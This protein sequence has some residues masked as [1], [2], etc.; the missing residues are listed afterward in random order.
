ME[1]ALTYVFWGALLQGLFL[2]FIY[3]FLDKQKNLSN[4]LL[5][6]FLIAIV[7]EAFTTILPFNYL[8]SYYVA[9]YFSLPEVKLFI[10]LLFLHFVMQ[11]LGLASKYRTFLKI[12]YFLATAIASLFILNL[13]YYIN[14]SSSIVENFGITLTDRVHYALQCYAFVVS[15]L[16]FFVLLKEVANYRALVKSEF[17]DYAMLQIKWLWQIIFAMLPV[18]LLWGLELLRI[19][20]RP[21]VESYFVSPIWIFITIFIYFISYRAYKNP[22]LFKEF[23]NNRFLG[24]KSQTYE[25]NSQIRM[26]INTLMAENEFY[27]NHDLTIHQFAKEVD[28]P[29]RLISACI[30]TAYQQNFNEWV[31]GFRVKKACELIKNDS[32]HNLSLEGIGLESGFK[33]RSVFYSA[34]KNIMGQTPGQFR[35]NQI[36]RT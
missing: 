11:K 27:L 35:P 10:P 30:N 26:Q 16:V 20:I 23:P 21:E 19:L 3:I 36:H 13:Y 24:V 8:R 2:S 22:D 34:F 18:I 15:V 9:E 25:C 7:L 31:N 4:K 14:D 1:A 29:A 28:L 6:L 5:G 33:S 12:H 32:G 17:S